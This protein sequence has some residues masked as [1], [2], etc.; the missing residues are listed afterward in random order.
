MMR[1]L[2]V[3]LLTSALLAT[4]ASAEEQYQTPSV[5]QAEVGKTLILDFPGN[6]A[7][8]HRWRLVDERSTGLT[9]VKVDPLGWI[10]AGGGSIVYGNRDTMRYRVIPRASGQADLTFEHNYRGWNQKYYFKWKTVRLIIS[11]PAGQKE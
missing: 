5:R 7:M 8:A 9:L 1:L 4:S 3:V 10:I 6:R 11:P 2:P